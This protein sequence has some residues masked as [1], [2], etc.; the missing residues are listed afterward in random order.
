[1]GSNDLW[2]HNPTTSAIPFASL[3]LDPTLIRIEG[4][5]DNCPAADEAA[6]ETTA[7]ALVAQRAT[8]D[9]AVDQTR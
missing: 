9:V 3:T 4:R 2:K 1:M 6:T 7:A 5:P 8:V